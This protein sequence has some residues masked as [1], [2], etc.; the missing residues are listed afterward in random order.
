[1]KKEIQQ[2]D[3]GPKWWS[4]PEVQQLYQQFDTDAKKAASPEEGEALLRRFFAQGGLLDQKLRDWE[5]RDVSLEQVLKVAFELYAFK[6]FVFTCFFLNEFSEELV[7][8]WQRTNGAQSG[9]G[10][11]T[12]PAADVREAFDKAF[13]QCASVLDLEELGARFLAPDGIISREFS[14]ARKAD[15]KTQ[16]ATGAALFRLKSYIEYTLFAA[17]FSAKSSAWTVPAV[18]KLVLDFERALKFGETEEDFTALESRYQGDNGLV[19]VEWRKVQAQSPQ[20]VHE[21]ELSRL[22]ENI[23]SFLQQARSSHADE[24]STTTV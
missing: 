2:K 6:F 19:A 15:D 22:N 10:E 16:L 24:K 23:Q 9:A 8:E 3:E 18:R 4:E 14:K 5:V 12:G 17:D 21:Q 7:L 13:G 11:Y 1:M 20:S